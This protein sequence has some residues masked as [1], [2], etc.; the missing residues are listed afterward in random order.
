MM[1]I[2]EQPVVVDQKSRWPGCYWGCPSVRVGQVVGDA[3]AD[4]G[5]AKGGS[6]GLRRSAQVL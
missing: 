5:S 2:A 3:A 6:R 1:G 4:V